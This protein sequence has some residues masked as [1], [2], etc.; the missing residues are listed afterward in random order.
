MFMI[1]G[2][3]NPGPEYA[4]T[5]HNVGFLVVDELA[6]RLHATFKLKKSH[7]AE[8]AEG[9]LEE[10]R[11]V[12][13]K[14]QTFMNESGRAVKS[15]AAS[16]SIPPEHILLVYD[17]ADL[18]FGKIVYRASGSSA[19][20]NGVQSVLD[21]FPADTPIAR[22]R[23]GIGRPE[24]PLIPLENWVLGTWNGVEQNLIAETVNKAVDEIETRT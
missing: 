15:I 19:G 10:K 6:K 8:V 22:V 5:R 4:R 17:D 20:H 1:V 13:A 23:I 3:G 18:A 2:L 9:S 16:L 24:N 14:P 11:I 7:E 21:Q 12:L